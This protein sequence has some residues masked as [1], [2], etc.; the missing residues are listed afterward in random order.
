[1]GPGPPP[2]PHPHPQPCGPSCRK[3]G[4]KEAPP[5]FRAQCSMPGASAGPPATHP[6]TLVSRS[7]CRG[8]SSVGRRSRGWPG[9]TTAGSAGSRTARSPETAARQARRPRARPAW[10]TLS[11][12]GPGWAAPAP[13]GSREGTSWSRP[14]PAARPH[15]AVRIAHTR[16]DTSGPR[17][18][19]DVGGG[20]RSPTGSPGGSRALHPCSSVTLEG[21]GD[22]ALVV[23][24]APLPNRSQGV[25]TGL[26]LPGWPRP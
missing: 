16:K 7:R 2:S 4:Q 23:R 17:P 12:H 15:W 19:K 1:M 10:T 24:E 11:A 21:L 8:R 6:G 9:R 26:S 3:V 25:H 14:S 18:G 22:G 20:G 5:G 13:V